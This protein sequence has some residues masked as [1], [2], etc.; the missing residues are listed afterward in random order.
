MPLQLRSD[1]IVSLLAAS[2]TG[3]SLRV[4]WHGF[5]LDGTEAVSGMSGARARVLVVR[6]DHLGDLLITLPAIRAL[7]R[8]L[9]GARITCLVPHDL[10]P[11]VERAVD[12]DE[13]GPMPFV[14]E[15]PPPAPGSSGVVG[16]AIGLRDRFDLAVLPR[17]NDP[18]SGA[19]AAAAGI[20]VRVG[21]R[22]AATLPFLTHAFPEQESR[23]VAREA[24]TLALRAAGVLGAGRQRSR[25]EQQPLLRVLPGDHHSAGDVVAAAGV[26]SSPPIVLHPTAGWPLKTWPIERWS[27]V[28]VG[29]AERLQAPVL[30]VGQDRD[31]E[32][33]VEIANRAGGSVR[34]VH[35]VSI[36]TLAGV[37]ARARIVVGMDSGALHLA[38]LTGAPVVALFGPFGPGRFAPLGSH[39]RVRTLWRALP[40]SPCG[41]VEAPPCGA[42]HHPAC[43]V[44]ISDQEV[45]RAAVALVT[46]L[47]PPLSSARKT[48]GP[49]T[50]PAR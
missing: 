34:P 32:Q 30:V 15:R 45:I 19:V 29:L 9:P 36:G 8:R 40:C 26:E 11:V 2:R 6:P 46:D 25:G 22:H 14:L 1:G 24:V 50:S 3:P 12:V 42:T 35:G 37:H 17:P 5:W 28:A 33:L 23:H 48:V 49:P 38:A 13:V 16:A 41:T 39:D 4:P 43:L 21:H 27:R 31:Q 18:W 7:R 10:I 47:R 20:P 44:S